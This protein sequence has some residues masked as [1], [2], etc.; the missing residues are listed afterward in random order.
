M[1]QSTAYSKSYPEELLRNYLLSEFRALHCAHLLAQSQSCIVAVP[2]ESRKWNWILL[3][4]LVLHCCQ[5]EVYLLNDL[6]T[7]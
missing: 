4:I 2:P 1:C 5:K 6:W 3:V 7:D